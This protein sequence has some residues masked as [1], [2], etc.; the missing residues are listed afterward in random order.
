MTY[1]SGANINQT[2]Q[3]AISHLQEI[4]LH[5]EKSVA[6]QYQNIEKIENNIRDMLF[7]IRNSNKCIQNNIYITQIILILCCIM[8]I[9]Q[10]IYYWSNLYYTLL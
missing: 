9:I 5:L 8:F 7:N 10:F 2:T 3:S 1:D 6:N 4:S